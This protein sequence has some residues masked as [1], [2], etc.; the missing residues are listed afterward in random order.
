[1]TIFY[2][3]T[4]IITELRSRASNLGTSSIIPVL[5]RRIGG[6]LPYTSKVNVE[7]AL[8]L[9]SGKFIYQEV[10]CNERSFCL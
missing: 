1:M 6:H 4:I 9:P 8:L 3:D 10:M 7:P 5:H 2:I